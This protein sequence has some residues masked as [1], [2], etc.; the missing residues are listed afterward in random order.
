MSDGSS[1]QYTVSVRTQSGAP[2]P[3]DLSIAGLPAGVSASFVAPQVVSGA[4]TTLVLTAAADAPPAFAEFAVF[5][6]GRYAT[7]Q[8]TATLNVYD[9]MAPAISLTN[10]AVNAQVSGLVHLAADANDNRAVAG[11]EI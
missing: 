1:V 5:A 2:Q 7:H 9:A 3:V 4:S 11:V 6:A 10:P 8:A